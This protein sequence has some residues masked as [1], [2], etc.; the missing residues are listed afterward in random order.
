MPLRIVSG[1]LAWTDPMDELECFGYQTLREST[2]LLRQWLLSFAML[3]SPPRPAS[4]WW[5]TILSL[6]RLCVMAAVLESL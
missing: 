1:L 6:Q 4:I 3:H 5:R 2:P